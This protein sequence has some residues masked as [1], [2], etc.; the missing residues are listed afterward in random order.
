L[1]WK[2]VLTKGLPSTREKAS[3][4]L[5]IYLGNVPIKGLHSPRDGEKALF[6]LFIVLEGRRASKTNG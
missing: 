6:Q 3:S 5:Y 1:P 4:Q 2:L